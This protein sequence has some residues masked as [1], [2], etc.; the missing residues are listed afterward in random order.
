MIDIPKLITACDA[1]WASC[2]ITPA[3]VV[4][5]S[6][7]ATRLLK[8]K[9][10]YQDI[11]TATT[12]PWFVVAVIHE[13]EASQAWWANIANGE[14]WNRITR[15]VPRG[16]GPFSNWRAAA[17]DALTQC[18][19]YTLR[20][21]SDWKDWSAGGTLVLLEMYNG[22]GYEAVHHEA[23]PYIWAATN[24]EEWGKYVKDSVWSP[25]VWDQQLGCAA[26]L[27]RMRELDPSITF[28]GEAVA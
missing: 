13:R 7:V 9:S 14:P 22:F 5:V 26:M 4:E 25:H 24:H 10:T 2:V 15:Q 27:L 28:T 11:Q 3:R 8:Y 19:L 23:S 18:P 20:R 17:I 12:V 16:R 1:L 21:V 6:Q